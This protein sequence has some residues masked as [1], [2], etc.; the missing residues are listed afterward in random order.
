LRAH[1]LKPA[2]L[3]SAESLHFQYD[4]ILRSF[5]D[6]QHTP[7]KIS[8]IRPQVYEGILSFEV[9]FAMGRG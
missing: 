4:A 8:L 5:V 9:K 6:P 2:G 1:N 7:G 3:C